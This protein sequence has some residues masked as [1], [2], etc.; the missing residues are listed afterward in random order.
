MT[1]PDTQADPRSLSTLLQ[2]DDIH[3][4]QWSAQDLQD[5]LQHQLAAPLHL[6]LGPLSAE[7]THQLR[8]GPEPLNPRMTLRELLR[9]EHPPLELLKLIKRFAKICRRNPENPLPSEI[10]MFL[11]Y[12]SITVALLRL[13]ESISELTDRS[14]IRGLKWLHV[15]VWMS[16]D[17]RSLLQEGLE[18]LRSRISEAT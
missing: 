2:F 5:M 1:M 9:H 6:G 15:Q 4:H 3:R 13:N 16:Q 18:Y 11:Y 14:L 8:A 12:G 10:V 7:V 17:M